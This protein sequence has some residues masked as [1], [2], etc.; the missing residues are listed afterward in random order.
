MRSWSWH[1]ATSKINRLLPLII[2]PLLVIVYWFWTS[3][4]MMWLNVSN[5][6]WATLFQKYLAD[7]RSFKEQEI[8]LDQCREF[9]IS[10][11]SS[12]ILLYRRRQ[13]GRNSTISSRSTFNLGVTWEQMA[14]CMDPGL[15]SGNL[16]QFAIEKW[17]F[18]V[19]LPTKNCVYWFFIVMLVYQR[20]NP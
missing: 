14:L 8:S 5:W 19:D 16:L 1:W 20:V 18:T 15:L 10:A 7:L 6:H 9:H 4:S 2:V 17:P 3:G 11:F 13:R 12:K